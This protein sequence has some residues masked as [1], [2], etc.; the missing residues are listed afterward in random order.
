MN[1]DDVRALA[2]TLPETC[3]SPH[4]DYASFR[5]VGKIFLTAPPDGAHLHCF[6]DEPTR[7]L[8]LAAL[9]DCCEALHWGKRVVGL[10]VL[11]ADAPG[12]EVESWIRAAWAH[13][14]PKRLL[15]GR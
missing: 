4:F 6:V 14:A 8:A 11:L 7:E 5:V 9:P 2:L 15:R 10:R 13:K 3:E 1:L 12:D